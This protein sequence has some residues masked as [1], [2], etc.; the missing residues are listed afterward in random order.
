MDT[1]AHPITADSHAPTV[2]ELF[3]G[4]FTLGLIGFG[5]VL[6]LSRRMLV[7]KRHWMSGDE[8]TELLGLCQFLPGGNIINMSVAIG[9]KFRGVAGAL[10]AIMGLIAMPTA[11]VIGLGVIYDQFHNDPRIQHMFAGLAA[12]AA[13]Q[14]VSMAIKIFMPM[15]RRPVAIGM[16]LLCF[17]AIA[18]LGLPMLPSLLILSPI[19]IFAIWKLE[20]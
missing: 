16:A 12:A 9:L 15:R 17:M 18:G 19:S 8:F 4:F 11:V 5:G 10:A 20:R 1:R 6:P 14:L 7:E 2:G 13:G 3:T